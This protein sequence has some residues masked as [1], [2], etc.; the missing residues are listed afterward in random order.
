VQERLG[1][2][3]CFAPGLCD[4]V[5]EWIEQDDEYRPRDAE[6]N[7]TVK[8]ELGASYGRTRQG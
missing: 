6:A 4:C 7:Q 1:L 5:R 2:C 8:R 3:G